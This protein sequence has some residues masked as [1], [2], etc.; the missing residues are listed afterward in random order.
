MDSTSSYDQSLYSDNDDSTNLELAKE[1]CLINKRK[2][3]SFEDEIL[4]KYVYTYGA[5]NWSKLADYLPG[6]TAKQC[7]ER[8]HNH[9][10]PHIENVKWTEEDDE[11]LL[12][13]YHQFGSRWS[14]ISKLFEGRS[15]SSIRNRYNL[16]VRAANKLIRKEIKIKRQKLE[17]LKL[18]YFKVSCNNYK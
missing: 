7:R 5:T 14:M 3:T 15:D 16:L 12:N 8:W 2:W 9:L 4:I 10:D 6:R 18:N 11:N 17:R 1:V 13:A